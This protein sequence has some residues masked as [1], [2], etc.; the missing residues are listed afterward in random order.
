MP[1]IGIF[2]TFRNKLALRKKVH[3]ISK[4][5]YHFMKYL[6]EYIDYK[7]I[8]KSEYNMKYIE[9]S[10]FW[11]NHYWPGGEVDEGGLLSQN[12]HKMWNTP[13]DPVD[14]SIPW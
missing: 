4:V 1:M 7:L 3:Y 12:E 9:V 14:F 10:P 11:V 2:F 6:L 13:V 5:S 8:L